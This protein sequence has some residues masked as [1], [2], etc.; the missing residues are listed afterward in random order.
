MPQ[1]VRSSQHSNSDSNS[2]ISSQDS[3]SAISSQ[4]SNSDKFI[5]C[6]ALFHI[7]AQSS[8]N[9]PSGN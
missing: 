8:W 3:N 1:T 6:I 2:A 9:M 5:L 7:N 4:D